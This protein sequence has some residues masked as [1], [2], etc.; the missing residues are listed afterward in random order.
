M[1]GNV[2]IDVASI[3]ASVM[4]FLGMVITTVFSYRTKKG[5]GEVNDSVNHVHKS[6]GKRLYDL[7]LENHARVN[8]VKEHTDELIQWKRSYH[9]SPWEDG[10][11]VKKWLKEHNEILEP[12]EKTDP[13][14]GGSIEPE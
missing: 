11:G 4:T 7:A 14:S 2:T 6:G 13:H 1:T 3:V 5:I 12:D 8:E 9:G 10:D